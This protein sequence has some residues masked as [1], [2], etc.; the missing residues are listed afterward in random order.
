MIFKS[1][2]AANV[3]R[4]ELVQIFSVLDAHL[5]QYFESETRRAMERE[6]TRDTAAIVPPCVMT[7]AVK[8]IC[9]IDIAA[10]MLIILNNL[11]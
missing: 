11:F 1:T 4:S 8:G 5:F 3:I 2:I 6:T 7:S 9:T 10:T